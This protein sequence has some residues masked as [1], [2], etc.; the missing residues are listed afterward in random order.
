MA[1]IVVPEI[2]VRHDSKT[3]DMRGEDG[4]VKEEYMECQTASEIL[5]NI[6][7]RKRET[8]RVRV[9]ETAAHI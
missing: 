1:Y 3:D 8:V 7:E 6:A 2:Y 5:D 4:V 9:K